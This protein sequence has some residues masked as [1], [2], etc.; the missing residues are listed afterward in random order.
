VADRFRRLGKSEVTLGSAVV[1][2]AVIALAVTTF[3]YLEPPARK[4]FRFETTDASSLSVGQD[5]RVAGVS[6]GK[7]TQMS[8]KPDTVVVTAE[9]ED[10]LLVGTESRIDVRMLTPVGGYAVTLIPL[11]T[12]SLGDSPLPSAQVTVPY[13]IGDVLQAAPHTTDNVDGETVDANINEVAD[14][15]Q[16]N[17]GSVG[18]LISGMNSIAGVM[19]RQ[20]DQVQEIMGLASEYLE[21]FNANREF[22]FDL[23]SQIN[24]VIST[25]NNSHVGFNESYRLLGNVLMSVQPFM[26]FYL[27]HKEEVRAAI[28]AT[29]RT[30]AEFETTMGPAI[31]NLKGLQ[32][33]LE[34]WLT[35]EG[36]VEI[37]G[38]TLVASKLCIPIPG[39]TC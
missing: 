25:Y 9:V 30:I 21:S 8:I 39:R 2:V 10:S 3:L 7:V 18:S 19:D 17:S 38:G 11:G 33:Q 20:R 23:I 32:Q 15:L 1:L 29:Q 22:V 6:V 28:E 4:S 34:Q 35:P 36:L 24:I 31:D 37:G 14:A 26:G 5:V 16:H 27:D 12:Q 13:S